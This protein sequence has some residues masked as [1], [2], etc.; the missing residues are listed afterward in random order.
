STAVSATIGATV[1]TTRVALDADT[2]VDAV[3]VGG[4][5]GP[6]RTAGLDAS[7]GPVPVRSARVRGGRR[8]G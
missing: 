3:L 2:G 4:R 7:C 8:R 1:D 6:R 5:P